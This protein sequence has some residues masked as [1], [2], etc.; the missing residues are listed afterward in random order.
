MWMAKAY[1]AASVVWLC[2]GHDTG[3]LAYSYTGCCTLVSYI[4]CTVLLSS[5]LCGCQGI[6]LLEAEEGCGLLQI[7]HW[8]PVWCRPVWPWAPSMPVLL[9]CVNFIALLWQLH[10]SIFFLVL[11]YL[12]AFNWLVTLYCWFFTLYGF[13]TPSAAPL[14][15]PLLS[16]HVPLILLA[17]PVWPW[18]QSM[19]VLLV[20]TFKWIV[21]SVTLMLFSCSLPS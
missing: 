18:A 6:W 11:T 10:T 17:P 7:G 1:A 21:L 2:T 20:S 19:P 15:T 5:L 4:G 12:L 9:M 8:S 3:W 14:P 13:N 16:C